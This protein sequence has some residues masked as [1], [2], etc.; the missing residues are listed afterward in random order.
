[1]LEPH[2]SVQHCTVQHCTALYCTLPAHNCTPACMGQVCSHVPGVNKYVGGDLF[3]FNIN[4]SERHNADA[5]F[6]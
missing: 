3:C 1:M 4:C 2:S 5:N 6:A